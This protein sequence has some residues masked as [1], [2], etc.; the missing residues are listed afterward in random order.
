MDKIR[1]VVFDVIP[2]KEM[3]NVNLFFVREAPIQTIFDTKCYICGKKNV[4]SHTW[5]VKP[6]DLNSQFFVRYLSKIWVRLCLFEPNETQKTLICKIIS[7]A[8]KAHKAPVRHFYPQTRI[9]WVRKASAVWNFIKTWQK[10]D[11][12]K[13]CALKTH[14]TGNSGKQGSLFFPKVEFFY[15]SSYVR[16]DISFKKGPYVV[17]FFF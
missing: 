2:Q 8:T 3:Q 4:Q 7:F 11:I 1:K 9:I 5:I 15:K 14:N 12:Y 13:K 17:F 6:W 16:L 10:L